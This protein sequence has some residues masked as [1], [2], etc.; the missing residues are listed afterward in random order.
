MISHKHKFLFSH[1]NKC[2]G[3]TVDTM[4]VKYCDKF[5]EDHIGIPVDKLYETL[6]QTKHQNM[7]QMINDKTK[8]YF[9]FSFVRNPWDKL[10]SVFYYR[11]LRYGLYTS[12]DFK[13]F[14]KHNVKKWKVDTISNENANALQYNWLCDF[15]GKL[16]TDFIGKIENFQEDFNTIC[17]KIGIPRKQLPHK[18]ATKHKHYTEYYDDETK[19]LVAEKYAKDIET[20]GYEFGE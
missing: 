10:V 14:I 5:S 19:Q 16:V 3:T 11:R 8:D 15:N 2:G 17:D 12:I 4:L 13:Q 1:I 9:K 18:N 7:R 20:F 6:N